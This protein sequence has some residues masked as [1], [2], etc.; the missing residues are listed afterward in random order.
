MNR[1]FSSDE[2]RKSLGF[3]NVERIIPHLKDYFQPNYHISNINRDLILDIGEVDT[4]N[5]T[6]INEDPV[7]LPSIFGDVMYVDIGYGR[8]TGIGGAK[9]AIFVMDRASRYKCIFK[10]K[11][12]KKDTLSA[13][14]EF[15][16]NMS[17]AP[18]KTVT[19][20]GHKL[21]VKSVTDYLS[22]F[23]Y[24]VESAPPRHQYQNG[25]VEYN[26]RKMICM[27]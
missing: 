10:L 5:D 11:S 21:M 16:A 15:I 20:F 17:F 1:T 6:K 19:D 22:T 7:K 14:K 18:K 26:W 27:A 3:L 4:L 23:Q 13:F 9:Y 24:K 12:L 8:N 25:L 2:L